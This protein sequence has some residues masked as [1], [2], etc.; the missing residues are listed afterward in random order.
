MNVIIDVEGKNN[1]REIVK[2]TF[3]LLFQKAQD[4]DKTHNKFIR[5]Q[6][7]FRQIQSVN[8]IYF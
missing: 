5:L 2:K 1:N 4:R 3:I 6:F 8:M 7:F